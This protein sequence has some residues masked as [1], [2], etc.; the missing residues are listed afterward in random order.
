MN[1]LLLGAAIPFT[2]A[3][4]VYAL[5][6]FRAGWRLLVITP[7]LMTAFGLWAAAPDIPRLLRLHNLYLRLY[8]DPRCNVFLWHYAIDQVETDSSWPAVGLALLAAGLLAAALR[9]LA[10]AER[11]RRSAFG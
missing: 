7:V 6:G 5:R 4:I 9:E 2:A 8:A 3:A 1:H 11:A 10:L